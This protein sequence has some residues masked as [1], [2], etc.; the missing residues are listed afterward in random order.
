MKILL[1]HCDFIEYEAK[2]KAIA[3]AEPITETK[4]RLEECLV[5][6][7]SSEDGDD[8]EIAEKTVKEIESVAKQV[9]S[10][11][12]VV[13][14]FVHLT[15]KPAKP[16]VALRLLNKIETDLKKDYE[17]HRA[18]FG[19]Y[20]SFN[21][22]CKGHPLSE[23][24][25]EIRHSAGESVVKA[26]KKE[27]AY[28]YKELL[29]QISKTKL[30]RENLK[31]NDHRIL[32]QK[33]DLFSFSELAPGMV[34]WHNNG[35][36]IY[37]ELVNFWRDE[38]RKANYQEIS[39]PQILD[40][41]LW[42]ISGHW[43]K[44]ENQ[45]VTKYEDRDFLVKPMNCPGGML[46]FRSATRSYH[47][48]PM[49]VAELGIV[50][51][52]ELSGVLNGLFRVIKFTQD[53]AH[54]FCT[55]DE[56]MLQKEI[57]GV[58][59][60]I[61]HFFKKFGLE[62]DHV[63]LSTR[64]EKRIGSDEVWDKAEKILEKVLIDTKVKY[65]IN[66][67]DGAFYGPKIDFHLKDSLNRTWQC[68][69]IQLDFSM[70]ERFELEYIGSDGQPHRPVMLHRVVY[71]SLERFIGILLEHTNGALPTWLSPVQVKVVSLTDR[72][73]DMVNSVCHELR[74]HNVRAEADIRTNTVQYKIR[75]AELQKIPYILVIGDKEQESNTLAVRKR[76]E[77][78]KFGVGIE[79]FTHHLVDEIKKRI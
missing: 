40:K 59:N 12:I 37:N 42:Q 75:D 30:D 77:K 52:Q 32:G 49:R 28:D 74:K 48:L 66:P 38:H 5:V 54:I 79:E 8:E 7:T 20:K 31:E 73:I 47:E 26:V 25:R 50:H 65:K 11:R 76:G 58:M 1:T 70:P 45:F 2:K 9:N 69:T 16:D 44:Y 21:L 71:G 35:L 36:I 60:M 63:E 55:D 19:W 68:S 22:K 39:T 57:E 3:S 53:D 10:E 78:V 43:E 18:P 23:L 62:F 29:R 6:F 24:S 51:R 34:F 72:N 13:Y 64:P 46:V 61:F 14:P 41:K 27:E 17:V 15:S 33:L 56:E 4:H 67:G